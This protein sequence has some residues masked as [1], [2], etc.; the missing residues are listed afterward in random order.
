[1]QKITISGMSCGHC[2]AAVQT[3]LEEL[4][5]T[6]VAVD[7][8]AGAATFTPTTAFSREQISEAI[9]DAGFEVTGFVS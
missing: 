5:L 8:D 7:L 2:V 4:G 3:T 6:S 1:M 9:E